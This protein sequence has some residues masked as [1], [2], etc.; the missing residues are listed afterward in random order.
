MAGQILEYGEREFILISGL[1][2]GHYHDILYAKKQVPSSLRS[3][4][5]PHFED[6]SE[7]RLQHL[8]DLI[9][10]DGF[11]L[12]SDEDT[13]VVLQMYILLR[14]CMGRGHISSMP[15]FVLE[16]ADDLDSWNRYEVLIICSCNK[17]ISTIIK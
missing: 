10:D 1:K 15:P 16:L 17:L 12:L 13:V 6:V 5:F 2:H 8:Y 14:C 9:N 4:L 11:P 3:R 7:F